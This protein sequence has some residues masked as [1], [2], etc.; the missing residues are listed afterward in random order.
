MR[1]TPD[2]LPDLSGK[3]YVITGGNSGLGLEAAMILAKKGGR[4]VITARSAAKAAD[5]V[6][7]IR[8]AAPGAVVE[9]VSLDLADLD[10]VAEAAATLHKTCDHI[11][12]FINNAGVM[13]PP[14][15]RTKQGF[16]LQFGTNHL[17]HFRLNALL[18]DRFDACGTRI[19]PV[20]SMAH[21]QG[22]IDLDDLDYQ[23]R[24]YTPTEA[25]CQSKLANVM[26]AFELQRRLT[27]RGSRAVAIPC[28]PGYAATNLQTAG[29][30]MEGGSGFFR[31]LYRVTNALIA[32]SATEGA[33]ALTLAAADPTA[34]PG[35]YYGPT[36]IARA[37]GPVGECWIAPQALDERVAAGLWAQSE[38]RVGP[39][40]GAA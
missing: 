30:G 18:F 27:A 25:Y 20:A 4:V 3:T 24:T 23:R 33:Y 8:A 14:L 19:V 32:Q 2:Q 15:Q 17:G 9:V 26:Y 11:D 13:Q 40:F 6:E 22:R 38:A 16:E 29:V 10:S 39:F 35:A 37:R 36:G 21:E 34:K 1:W 28:H 12:A 5:A 31:A 7:R